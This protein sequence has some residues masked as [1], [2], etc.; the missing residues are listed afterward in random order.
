MRSTLSLTDA[1][2]RFR[3]AG[4]K[5]ENLAEQFGLLADYLLRG[6]YIAVGDT[7][8]V[9]LRDVE[10]YYH[11]EEGPVK[12]PVMYHR[13]TPA[14]ELPYLPLGSLYPHVSGIDIAFENP[15]RCYR[16]SALV[17]GYNLLDGDAPLPAGYETRS[18]YLYE[19]LLCGPSL[20]DGIRLA[21][22]PAPVLDDDDEIVCSV[23]RNVPLFSPDGDKLPYLGE[24]LP[25]ENR[26][27]LQDPRPWRFSRRINQQDTTPR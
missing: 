21:W 23:R 1:L 26:R 24:G 12:D 4:G 19:A 5:E 17:R 15:D 2:A 16:A 9:Y 20:A 27:H 6:G 11:E 14:A 8:R 7:R 13:N 18:T 10:F 25:T 22:V 3:G